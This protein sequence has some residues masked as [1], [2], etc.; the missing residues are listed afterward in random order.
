MSRWGT[1][2]ASERTT[3][4]TSRPLPTA[5]LTLTVTRVLAGAVT[6]WLTCWPPARRYEMVTFEVRDRGLRMLSHSWKPSPVYPSAKCHSRC[7]TEPGPATAGAS[8]AG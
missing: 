2:G 4:D 5:S 1:T 6:A 7:G 8:E 3:A